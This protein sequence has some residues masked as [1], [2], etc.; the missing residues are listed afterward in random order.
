MR[1]F[2]PHFTI[3]KE[4]LGWL[5]IAVGAGCVLVML[6]AEVL[7]ADSGGFGTVQ[8]IGTVGG[9]LAMLLG[10]TLLPLGAQPA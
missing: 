7:D 3:T 9:G 4:M 10:I 8:R 2:A 1:V 6:G 5:L